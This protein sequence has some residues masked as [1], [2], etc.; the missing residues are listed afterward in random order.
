MKLTINEA[1]AILYKGQANVAKTA[2]EVGV[3]V[4]E[5]KRTFAFY[6]K[7]IPLTDDEWKKDVEVCWPYHT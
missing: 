7:Q 5:M 3:P 4:E 2:K 1:C 6:A